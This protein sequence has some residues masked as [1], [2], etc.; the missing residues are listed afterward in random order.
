M[1]VSENR[2]PTADVEI[3]EALVRRLLDEAATIHGLDAG[4]AT[5]D[6]RL[7]TNGWDNVLYRLGPGHVVRLPRRST[8]VEL[9][10]NEHRWLPVLAPLLPIPIPVPVFAGAPSALFD[11]PWS[12]VPWFEGRPLGEQAVAELPAN[13]GDRLAVDL[14]D[15]LHRLHRPAPADAPSNR[16][17]GCPLATRAEL[18]VAHL[19]PG[20]AA[21]DAVGLDRVAG[22]LRAVWEAALDQPHWS[23]GARWLHGDLHPLNLIWHE[24]R[25]AAV[26]DFGDLC[27][28]DPATDLAVVWYVFPDPGQRQHV[29]HLARIDNEPV[30]TATWHRAAGWALSIACAIAARSAD[31]PVFARLSRRTLQAL[32]DGPDSL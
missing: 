3:D 31:H 21:L 1:D 17:R 16:Y 6:L 14:T 22:R 5:A 20:S 2:V 11:R 12:I 32:A 18:T 15:F 26:I 27:G 19:S 28:G 9:V 23:G 4:L 24:Y 7:L 30:D 10:D 25:L 29:R 13:V 8:A